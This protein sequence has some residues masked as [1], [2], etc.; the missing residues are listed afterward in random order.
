M[1]ELTE[2][3]RSDHWVIGN[4]YPV[5]EKLMDWG[6]IWHPE[7]KKW[8]LYYTCPEDLEY[9]AIARMGLKLE[10]CEDA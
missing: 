9:Q 4:S 2:E 5:K 6:C 1:A 10:P 7:E 8:K 3:K